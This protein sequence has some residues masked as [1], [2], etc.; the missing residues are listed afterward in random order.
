MP[1]YLLISFPIFRDTLDLIDQALREFILLLEDR[2]CNCVRWHWCVL[3]T[4]L[5]RA[6][7]RYFIRAQ[8]PLSSIVTMQLWLIDIR[9][10]GCPCFVVFYSIVHISLT[11]RSHFLTDNHVGIV[12]IWFQCMTAGNFHILVNCVCCALLISIDTNDSLLKLHGSI[13]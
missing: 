2:R 1:K 13:S 5:E 6:V 7:L 9:H 12:L 11:I 3:L 8:G 4:S 10:R